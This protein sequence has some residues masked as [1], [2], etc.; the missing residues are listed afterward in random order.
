VNK[1]IKVININVFKKGYT[2]KVCPVV[3]GRNPNGTKNI[4]IY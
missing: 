2:E 3:G 4:N 1:N